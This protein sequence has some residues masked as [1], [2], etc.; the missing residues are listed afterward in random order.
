VG[1]LQPDKLVG[2][3]PVWHYALVAAGAAGVFVGIKIY[4][5]RR[6]VGRAGHSDGLGGIRHPSGREGG[7]WLVFVVALSSFGCSAVHGVVGPDHFREAIIFGVFFAV[8]STLQAAWGVAV[9]WRPVRP[10]LVAGAAGN[11][12][13]VALWVVTRTVGLPVGPD[14]W[15]PEA[16][17]A[18]DVMA[19]ALEL[20]I[21]AGATWLA[22]RDRRV[23]RLPAARRGSAWSN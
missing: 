13:V 10:L 7:R 12:G 15:R 8:A 4:E 16:V 3:H 9:L 19:T 20:V 18:L 23:E 6:G 2:T 5:Y 22:G 14:V 21:V 17:S 11:L 1:A